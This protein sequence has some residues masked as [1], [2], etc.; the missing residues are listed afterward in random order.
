MRVESIDVITFVN[1]EV[2][3]KY[4]WRH[5]VQIHD[6]QNFIT[7]GKLKQSLKALKMSSNSINCLKIEVKFNKI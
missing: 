1:V 3:F 6:K 5:F 4:K 2:I 7:F